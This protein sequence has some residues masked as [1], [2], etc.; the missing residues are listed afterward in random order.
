MKRVNSQIERSVDRSQPRLAGRW[1]WQ[2]VVTW[3]FDPLPSF[4]A[5]LDFAG[6]SQRRTGQLEDTIL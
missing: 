2:L 4:A 6:K 1:S 3:W 5:V